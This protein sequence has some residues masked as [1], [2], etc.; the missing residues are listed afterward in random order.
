MAWQLVELPEPLEQRSALVQENSAIEAEQRVELA[1]KLDLDEDRI[2]L[3]AGPS[4]HLLA[5][6]KLGS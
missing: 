5:G 4:A 2:D 6:C 3:V 1:D